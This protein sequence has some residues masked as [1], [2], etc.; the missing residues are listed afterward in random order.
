[1][2]NFDENEDRR[3]HPRKEYDMGVIKAAAS[4]YGVI[5]EISDPQ[6]RATVSGIIEEALTN[7]GFVDVENLVQD[8]EG[9]YVEAGEVITLLDALKAQFPNAFENRITITGTE[10]S[11]AG[12]IIVGQ[13]IG[14]IE[15]MDPELD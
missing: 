11:P 8:G 4:D 1:M 15:L 5:V 14:M 3:L 9:K 7:A 6:V 13:D 2:N 12:F 10:E